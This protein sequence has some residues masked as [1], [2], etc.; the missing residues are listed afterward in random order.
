MS[1]RIRNGDV[2]L[3]DRNAQ[4]PIAVSIRL[5]SML[6]Y[7]VASP[8]T[9]YSHAAI[10]YYASAL[11]AVRIVEATAASGV[12]IALLPKY[13]DSHSDVV[14]THV[15]EHHWPDVKRYLDDVL[16]ARTSYDFVT[17]I[18]LT[19]YSLTGTKLC[20]QRAG[21]AICSGLVCDALTRAGIVWPRPPFACTPADISA[22]LQGGR[23]SWTPA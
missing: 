14:A 23:A 11:D 15:D 22:T 8:H 10:V 21:S 12:Q 19:M 16:E 9:R 20:I 1:A 18:G 13:D 3:V 7:G 5:G 17:Y 6:R 4:G 2:V